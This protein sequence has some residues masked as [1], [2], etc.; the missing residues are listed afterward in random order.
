MDSKSPDLKPSWFFYPGGALPAGGNGRQV[1]LHRRDPRWMV[2]NRTAREIADQLG[3][4]ADCARAAAGLADRYGLSA[5]DVRRDV[6]RVA[7]ELRANGFLGGCG[8]ERPIRRPEADSLFLHITERCNFTCVHCYRA[9]GHETA[10][11]P[12]EA[13]CRLLD[14][15]AAAGCR[16]VTLSGGEPLLHPRAR[17]LVRHAASKMRVRLLTNGSLLD[18]GWAALL[19]DCGV[20]V[21]VSVDG[22]DEATHDAIR[23]PGSHAAALRAVELM[24]DAGMGE[25]IN[26]S[27][28][29]MERNFHQLEAII[30]LAEHRR[31]P[32]VRFLPLSR[33]GRAERNWERLGTGVSVKD[34]EA[35]YRLVTEAQRCGRCAIDVSCGLSGFLLE[36][37]E[38]VAPDGIWC[39]VGRT[40]VADVDGSAYPC[41]LLMREEFHSGNLLDDGLQACLEH[42]ALA[43]ACAALTGRRERIDE[44]AACHWRN[45]CQAGCMG[46]ALDHRGTIWGRDD[47]CDYRR[48]AF[49]D[50]FDR[51]LQRE[52]SR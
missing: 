45:L 27:T 1:M 18:A 10:D 36:V 8:E 22:A 35:F 47:F 34:H 15:A 50:A 19:A 4:G 25:R 31:V 26:F 17:D 52:G 40:L 6:D 13:A 41:V 12:L 2:V 3:G 21:Q 11:M 44:C 39:S 16:G 24:R 43:G 51:I 30:R 9:S 42:P 37:P 5:G 29:I 49:R 32:L 14:E 33:R 7:G 48:E 23:V 38:A 20:L 28:T 46:Q